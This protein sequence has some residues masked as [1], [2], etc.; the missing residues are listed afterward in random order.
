MFLGPVRVTVSIANDRTSVE[1]AESLEVGQ[2]VMDA[3]RVLNG[4]GLHEADLLTHN[5]AGEIDYMV[6][7]EK[8]HQ[9]QVSSEG[10]E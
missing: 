9:G 10:N 1:C 5:L 4:N 6:E 3:A 2:R 8:D 7:A